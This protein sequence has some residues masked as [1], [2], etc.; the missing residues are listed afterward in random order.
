MTTIEARAARRE[1]ERIAANLDSWATDHGIAGHL[2][3]HNALSMAAGLVRHGEANWPGV[4][5][6]R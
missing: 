5:G 2:A 1:R 4:G 6:H 3:H